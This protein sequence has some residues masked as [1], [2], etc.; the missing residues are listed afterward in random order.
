MPVSMVYKSQRAAINCNRVW[1]IGLT[2]LY[3]AIFQQK[4]FWTYVFL[5]TIFYYEKWSI[6]DFPT[7]DRKR[8]FGGG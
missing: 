2:I 1:F 7:L 5:I 4:G 6:R 3:V 8:F